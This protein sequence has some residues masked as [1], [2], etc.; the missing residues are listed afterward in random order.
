MRER[1]RE[2]EE[3]GWE[4]EKGTMYNEVSYI[5]LDTAGEVIRFSTVR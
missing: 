4:R 1:E 2:R 3:R 5:H